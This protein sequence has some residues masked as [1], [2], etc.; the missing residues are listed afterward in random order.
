[1]K[2]NTKIIFD[3]DKRMVTDIYYGSEHYIVTGKCCKC[4]SC[5]RTFL[6]ECQYLEDN[7]KCI[8]HDQRQPWFCVF[9]PYDIECFNNIPKECTYKITK[10]CD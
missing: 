4:G 1:M 9:Y 8:I 10:V 2:P 6:P 3:V 7:N 5:C